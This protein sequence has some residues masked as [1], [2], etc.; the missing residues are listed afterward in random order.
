MPCFNVVIPYVSGIVTQIIEQLSKQMSAF[1]VHK[2]IVIGCRLTLK[3]IAIIK[4]HHIFAVDAALLFHKRADAR[5][6]A[7]PLLLFDKII[8]KT[9][10][11]NIR[12]VYHIDCHNT[13]LSCRS[14]SHRQNC[15]R[16]DEYSF[17][18]FI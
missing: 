10:A 17:H 11:V 18:F 4:Q 8:R 2:I 16:E 6:T 13:L 1:G 15:Q 5:I 3:H 9:I 7:A 12:G 14:K